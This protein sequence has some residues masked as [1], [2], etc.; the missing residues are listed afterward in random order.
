MDRD[1]KLIFE[2]YKSKLLLET[3]AVIPA[4]LAVGTEILIGLATLFG[5]TGIAAQLKKFGETVTPEEAPKA[6]TFTQ[7]LES[8]ASDLITAEGTKDN[9]K[10][11]MAATNVGLVLQDT[12]GPLNAFFASVGSTIIKAVNGYNKTG[13]EQYLQAG[14][15]AISQGFSVL[16]TS[17]ASIPGIPEQFVS[18]FKQ[19]NSQI[20]AAASSTPLITAAQ[21]AQRR[22]QQQANQ[23]TPTPPSPAP[24]PPKGP[25][26]G[27]KAK[28]LAKK[29]VEMVGKGAKEGAKAVVSGITFILNK[30]AGISLKNLIKLIVVATASGIGYEIYKFF[31]KTREEADKS[32]E[33]LGKAAEAST[34]VVQIGAEGARDVAKATDET[35]RKI[36]DAAGAAASTVQQWW[37]KSAPIIFPQVPAIP[38]PPAAPAVPKPTPIVLTPGSSGNTPQTPPANGYKV[39][40]PGS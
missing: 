37:Q 3:A 10:Y 20:T 15:V 17:L 7:N 21:A 31:R 35:V 1:S 27:Q 22:A 30:V 24:T 28:E 33:N 38:R 32:I 36:D 29:G 39:R 12:P 14:V 2:A 9:S 25:G 34:E 40:V 23:A 4:G 13:D 11:E 5:L 18:N 16:S 6:V 19:L 8:A 26:K